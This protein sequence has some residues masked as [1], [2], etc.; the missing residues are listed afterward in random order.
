[1]TMANSDTLSEAE[2]RKELVR[3]RVLKAW[4]ELL[5]GNG[6]GETTVADVAS[7]AGLARSSVYRYFPD[8]EA[9][10]FAYIEDR[11]T[12]FVIALRAD[13]NAEQDAPSRLRRLVIGELRRFAETPEIGLS[14]VPELLSREGRGRLLACF[15]PL[16]DL[17]AEILEQGRSEGTLP[18]LDVDKALPIVFA[19]IDVFRVRLARQWIDPDAIADDIADFVLRGLGSSSRTDAG[20]SSAAPAAA[21]APGRV[22]GA[23]RPLT[24][25]PPASTNE[26]A[27]NRR[28]GPV[29][30]VLPEADRSRLPSR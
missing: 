21:P 18:A 3:R 26:A 4:G 25:G 24:S 6:Y 11:I 12:A 30:P 7:R 19:C 2:E 29:A 13:V 22:D 20:T 27:V 28:L 5:A 14:D 9:L 16:R 17:V 10:F 8:K 15:Q 1:M 23:P